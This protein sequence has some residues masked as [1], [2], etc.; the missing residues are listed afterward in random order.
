MIPDQMLKGT[1]RNIETREN[2]D[3]MRVR[4][5]LVCGHILIVRRDTGTNAENPT[6][7]DDKFVALFC[8]RC[9]PPE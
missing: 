9:E 3:A 6:P 8:E 5:T 2:L 4:C 1:W 7:Y